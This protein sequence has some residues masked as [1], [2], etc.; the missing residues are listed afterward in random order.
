MEKEELPRAVVPVHFV[1][2]SCEMYRIHELSQQYGFQVVE[3][4]CHAVGGEYCK[5]N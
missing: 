2:Q 5:K 4:A 1:G 3:D